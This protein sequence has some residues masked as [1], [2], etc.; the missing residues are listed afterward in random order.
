[1]APIISAQALSKRYGAAPLFQNISFT[2]SEGDRIGVI[3]PNGSGKSTLLEI[4]CG[5][6]KP[7]SGD[8]A[9]RKGTRLSYV[10]QISEFTAGVTIQGVVDQALE[11]AAVP[12]AERAARS[13]ETLG[14][15]GFVELDALAATLSGGWRKRLAIAEALVENPDVLLLDE[16]TNHLDLEGIEWLERLLQRA[17]FASVVVSHDRYFLENV[18]REMVEIDRAYENGALRVEGNYSTFLEAKEEHLHAQR[19]RQQ[20]LENRVHTEIEWLRRGPKARATKAKARIDKAH[21]MIGELAEMKARSSVSTTQIDFSATNRQTKQLIELDGVT[22]EIGD[23]S[24]FAKL[25]FR[26]TS[27]M[28][29]GLVGP[30]GSGKTT[31]LRLLR[32]ELPPR[33]GTIRKAEPLRII[34]FD[35]NRQLDPELLLRR[36]LAPDSDSVLYQ[37]QVIHVASWAARFLFTGEDLNRR[38]GK[39]SGGERARVLIAQLMLQPADVLLLDEPTNDL[40]I[41]TLEILE[42]SLLEF[43]GALVLVTH[44]RYLLDRVS[45]VILGFDGLGH[46]GRFAD[47]SQWEK[48]RDSQESEKKGKQSAGRS[49]TPRAPQSGTPPTTSK[50]KLSYKETRELESME[51]RIAEAEQELRN[52]QAA[53]RDPAITSDGLRLHNA[54]LRLDEA[55]KTVD[56]LYARWAELEH[57][58]G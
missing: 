12:H 14:R 56:K 45:T 8:V 43:R 29:V 36:A 17:N 35:Q 34:Y 50:R 44:D 39:L 33:E 19:N 38:V 2:V 27:G 21:K 52:C 55:Q 30:N 15:A 6:T 58:Q 48:W 3:G 11:R 26:V 57:K 42:E 40:D 9:I 54:S 16:P 32:G 18:A 20:T 13:A 23:R 49:A 24:L 53:L 28:R 4:L 41:P 22:C 51:Q 10:K 47:Y 46:I 7:D 5:R 25:H 37:E 1:M 31:L